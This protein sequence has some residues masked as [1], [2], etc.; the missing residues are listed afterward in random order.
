MS[1]IDI[2]RHG[3]GY[4]LLAV[5][6]FPRDCAEV[7]SFFSDA[8]NLQAITPGKLHFEIL[9]D[10]P[11]EMRKG[12]ILDYRLRIRGVPVRWRTE[13]TS[14]EPPYRFS[15]MQL[16]GPYQWWIHEHRFEQVGN[17]TV[18]TDV[19]EYGVPLGWLAHPL[20][21]RNDLQDIFAF[22][23]RVM[24]KRFGAATAAAQNQNHHATAGPGRPA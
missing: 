3:K 21:V 16:R 19:V 9:S 2:R 17:E 5:Q 8:T 18:A 11:I 10:L 4:R 23:Q 13:I 7:F 20:F 14:W 24:A 6:R 15:D 1:Q 12:T 22:R